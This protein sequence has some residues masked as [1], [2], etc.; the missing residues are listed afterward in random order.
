MIIEEW[1]DFLF[2]SYPRLQTAYEEHQE[3]LKGQLE[4]LQAAS[5]KRTAEAT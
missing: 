1:I 4:I 5:K 3:L 2:D